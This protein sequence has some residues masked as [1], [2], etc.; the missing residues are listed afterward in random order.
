MIA[1]YTDGVVDNPYVPP[2]VLTDF[3]ILGKT[4]PIG[5]N[6]PLRRSI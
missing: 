3:Q 1:F 4:A 6:S 2:V 5:G